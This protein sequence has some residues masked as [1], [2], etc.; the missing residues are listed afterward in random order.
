MVIVVTHEF[1]GCKQMSSLLVAKLSSQR[2]LKVERKP[3][4][5]PVRRKMS[6]ITDAPEKV[7]RSQ[8]R[9]SFG[10]RDDVVIAQFVQRPASV[11]GVANPERGM[12]VAYAARTLLHI[13]LLETNRGA[14]FCVPR[15]PL[16]QDGRYIGIGSPA[17]ILFQ[18]L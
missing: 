9:S 16:A 4:G 2:G 17:T 10:F 18:R 6:R 15:S 1:F 5:L 12:K 3:F 11:P 7:G 8:S 13:G 14:I